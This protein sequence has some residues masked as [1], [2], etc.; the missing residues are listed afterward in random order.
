MALEIVAQVV[1]VVADPQLRAKRRDNPHTAKLQAMRVVQAWGE[2]RRH[3]RWIRCQP[4][5]SRFPRAKD[6]LRRF[7]RGRVTA[8]PV[9][10]MIDDQRL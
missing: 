8:A 1:A 7:H 6:R 10:P 4:A 5:H 9:S 3:A 2:S